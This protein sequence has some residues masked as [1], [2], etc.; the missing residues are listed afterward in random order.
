MAVLVSQNLTQ[1]EIAVRL[2]I[3]L[4]TVKVHLKNARQK[5]A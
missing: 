5:T 4:G 1:Y 2:G 3:A